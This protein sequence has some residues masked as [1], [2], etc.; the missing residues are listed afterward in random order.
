VYCTEP[1]PRWE[2]GAD[3]P[4]KVGCLLYDGLRVC[5]SPATT[6]AATES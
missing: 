5:P 3:C 6:D 4:E 2:L 1:H